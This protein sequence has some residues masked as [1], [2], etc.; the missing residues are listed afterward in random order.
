[1]LLLIVKFEGRSKKRRDCTCKRV[2][3]AHGDIG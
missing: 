2:A 3:N 1:M